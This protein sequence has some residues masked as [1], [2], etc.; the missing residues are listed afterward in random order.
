MSNETELYRLWHKFLRRSDHSQ[1]TP[2]VKRH[3]GDPHVPFRTWWDRHKSLFATHVDPFHAQR[4]QVNY[5]LSSHA[6]DEPYMFLMINLYSKKSEIFRALREIIRDEFQRSKGKPPY[7]GWDADFPLTGRPEERT[8]RRLKRT[9]KVYDAW[10]KNNGKNDRNKAAL[11]EIAHRLKL[12]E[13]HSEALEK[14]GKAASDAK[15]RLTVA[16]RDHVKHAENIIKLVCIG[17]FPVAKK[18]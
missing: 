7:D 6:E 17:Q 16:V 11:W 8:I 10:V 2:K 15:R 14:G 12:N 3:F 4:I 5:R 9:L 13:S 1:W 18:K